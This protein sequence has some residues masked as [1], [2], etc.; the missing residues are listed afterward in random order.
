MKK[1]CIDTS[2]CATETTKRTGNIVRHYNK[3]YLELGF[4]VVALGSGLS[5]VLLCVLYSEILANEG[6][7]FFRFACHLRT[8]YRSNDNIL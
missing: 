1:E 2:K 4:T 8:K 7:I 5:P 6:L 3:E